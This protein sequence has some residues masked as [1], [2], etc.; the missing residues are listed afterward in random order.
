VKNQEIINQISELP[1][2]LSEDWIEKAI[3][4]LDKSLMTL[5][6]EVFSQLTTALI[7]SA[8]IAKVSR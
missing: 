8:P 1:K 2:F 5:I 3:N 7:V 4:K 6:V